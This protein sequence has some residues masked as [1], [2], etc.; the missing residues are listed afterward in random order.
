MTADRLSALFLNPLERGAWG[1]VERWL[2]DL[3]VELR[4]R[5]HAIAS[6]GCPESAWT[7]RMEENGF[8]HVRV[9]LRSDFSLAQRRTL[10]AFMREHR[11][12]VVA[13]KLHRGIRAGGFAARAAGRPPVVAFMG[14]VE[15]EPGWRYRLTYRMFLDRVVTLAPP[16]RDAIAARGGLDPSHVEV[17]PY[18]VRPEDYDLPESE[19]AALRAELGIAADRPVAVAVGRMHLQKRFDQMLDAWAAVAAAMPQALLL[20]AGEGRLQEE[21][22]RKCETLGL[23]GSVRFL[24]FRRD[25]PRVLKAADC[26]AMSSDIEGLPMVV[27]ESMAAARPVVTTDVGSVR[28]MMDDG[29]HGRIV[30]IRDP[31]ALASALVSVLSMPD[32]G[33][34]LGAAGRRRVLDRFPLSRCIDETERYL[35]SVRR[36]R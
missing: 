34:A 33:R 24:G 2:F 26:L 36:P 22:V 20:F 12:D 25:V 32:R 18:G 3:A 9:P 13:T 17:I 7:K 6:A 19:G 27:L 16:M 31:A 30:P 21:L 8:P 10:A 15:T 1:G 14:L 35:L 29:A 11:V 5:G 28:A 23:G 4:G